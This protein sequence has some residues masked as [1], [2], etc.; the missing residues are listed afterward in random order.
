MALDVRSVARFAAA[1]TFESANIPLD[2]IRA[3]VYEL[4][5]P[6]NVVPV[7]Q[8]GPESDAA[9]DLL[10]EL[11]RMSEPVL[12]RSCPTSPDRFR[13]W[14]APP[15]LVE[16][17]G[18]LVPA[19]AL[20]LACG[21]GREAVHLASLGWEVTAIDWLPDALDRGKLL[22]SRYMPSSLHPIE[23]RLHDLRR[24]L[25]NI[26]GR[27][28]LVCELFAWHPLSPQ[29]FSQALLADGI[30]LWEG[31]ANQPGVDESWP[32]LHV[33]ESS[34][35]YREDRPTKRLILHPDKILE[36]SD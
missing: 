8:T 22:E 31:F 3:R 26:G 35:G 11:G 5:T 16:R 2:E 25:K 4:P 13:L 34:T 32:S 19:R 36:T 20:C 12:P 24:P 17:V 33:G 1:P 6:T 9:V 28:E 27:F 30:G 7:Y 15:F 14:E 21:V 29:H 18:G 23:W 10:S